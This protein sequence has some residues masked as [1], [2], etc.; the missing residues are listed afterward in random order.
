MG[1]V[2]S[3]F[4]PSPQQVQQQQNAE[5]AAQAQRY[6]QLDPFQRAT[7]GLYQ[8]G[9]QLAGAIA[10]A[11]GMVNP[12]MQ[13]AQ[14][15]Q[16]LT[17]GADI[18][19]PEGMR[20]L[21][22]KFQNAG[23]SQ[24]AMVL[25]SKAREAE[26]A[27]RAAMFEER[28]QALN[29]RKQDF[30]EQEAFDLKREQLKQRAEEA[31][32]RSEDTRLSIEQ[33]REAARESN[34]IRLLLGKMANAIAQ[35]KADA[36]SAPTAPMPTDTVD[37]YAAMSLAGDKSWQVGLARGKEGQRLIAAVK[38]RIPQMA[39]EAGVTPGEA[40]TAYDRRKVLSHAASQVQSRVAGIELSSQKIVKDIEVAR[41]VMK[42]GNINLPL[43]ASK[44]LNWLRT[45]TSSPELAA[46]RRAINQVATEYQRV[47]SGPLSNAMLHEGAREDAAR[48]MSEDMTIAE[49]EA[50]I[51]VMLRD[52]EN[53]KQAGEEQ[54]QAMMGKL[55]TLGVVDK[56]KKPVRKQ[57]I[58]NVWVEVPD[59]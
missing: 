24:Q 3:L 18:S 6:A 34:Q 43:I 4:G 14:V 5:L 50:I 56:G 25:L 7:A 38:E 52:I 10:P 53:A 32:Q 42:G 49:V 27:Q 16:E 57:R 36:A 45:Q 58:G 59:A 11:F 46:Y 29:E 9:G 12:A 23:M 26:A 48:M 40:A 22:V 20:A 44:P 15:Q 2:D 33:R 17:K 47:I 8:T 35:Q 30:N 21:A 13:Q 31:K 41:S 51:P 19:T 1:I 54:L 39:K 28:K 55:N 37:F